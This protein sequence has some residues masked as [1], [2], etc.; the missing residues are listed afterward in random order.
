M[1][2][3]KLIINIPKGELVLIDRACEIDKRTRA[4]LTRR[5]LAILVNKIL[6]ESE[7][8]TTN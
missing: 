7:N 4:S 3:G 1:E 8:A 6:L 5:A 2:Y